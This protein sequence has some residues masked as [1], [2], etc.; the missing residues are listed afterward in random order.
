MTFLRHLDERQK[1]CEDLFFL[2]TSEIL[3]K[4]FCFLRD[5]FCFGKHL[6]VVLR[7]ARGAGVRPPP[8]QFPIENATSENNGTKKPCFFSVF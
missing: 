3:R 7:V 4:F 8:P 1:I 6:R 2:T 5:Y